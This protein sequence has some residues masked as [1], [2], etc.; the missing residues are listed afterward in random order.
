MPWN[1]HFM[2]SRKQGMDEL[3]SEFFLMRNQHNH[4]KD[5]RRRLPPLSCSM[6]IHQAAIKKCLLGLRVTDRAAGYPASRN[7]CYRLRPNRQSAFPFPNL[8]RENMP[9]ARPLSHK[10][11]RARLVKAFFGPAM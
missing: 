7:S 5:L 2:A 9:F 1:G 6:N 8:T 10:L 11:P 3:V 4:E